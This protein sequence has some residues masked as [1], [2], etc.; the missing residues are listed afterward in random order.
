MLVPAPVPSQLIHDRNPVTVKIT[1]NE[2][3]VVP[4]KRRTTKGKT[5]FT[6]VRLCLC[7]CVCVYMHACACVRVRVFVCVCVFLCVCLRVSNAPVHLL[8]S[9]A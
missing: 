9:D 5:N 2:L 7:A 8:M 1:S 4:Q 3:I 6:R